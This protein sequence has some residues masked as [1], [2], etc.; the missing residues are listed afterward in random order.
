MPSASSL[1]R[2][3]ARA[4][5]LAALFFLLRS[6]AQ[7]AESLAESA[8]WLQQYLRLDTTNPPGNE[9]RGAELLAGI[10]RREGLAPR[11][12]VTP[13]GRVSLYARLEGREP[14]AVVLLH[15]M[16]VVRPGPQWTVEPFAGEIRR[17]TLMG[18]GALDVKSLGIA[19]L[20]A[21]IDLKRRGVVPRR[22]IVYLAVA[23]EEAGGGQGTAFVLTHYPELFTDAQVVLN[24]G[25]S[26]RV[27]DGQ[28]RWWGVEVAQKRPLWLRISAQGRAGHAAGLQPN[29]A[30]HELVR[31]LARM[32][33]LRPEYRVTP[34]ARTYLAALAPLHGGSLGDT[35]AHLDRAIGPDGPREALMPGMA[36]LFLDTV[37]V[38]VLAASEQI[39][40]IAAEASAQI[41]VR[42]LPDT[43]SG[44]FLARLKKALGPNVDT[45]LVLGAPIGHASSSNS[46]DW[47]ELA[48]ALG[49]EPVV[50]AFI[51]GF[52]DSRYFRD[53]GV[54]AYGISPFA[55]AG[56]EL[57]GIHG[58]DEGIPLAE[59]AAGCERLRRVVAALAK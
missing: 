11:L 53:R 20:A 30:A 35:L 24:E 39:N 19:E 6:P 9:Q 56:E 51:G 23:D 48:R 34:A 21:L 54:A 32:L 14:G 58:P 13:A 17:G 52:T 5:A 3:R 49:D 57:R 47:R 50:P 27:V 10:L 31:A 46:D 25:G 16:D 42:L 33:D 45:E 18:R 7:A 22:S 29:S 2:A 1:C 43:D 8:A 40:V 37:Q 55:L 15:H 36:A 26:N 44:A 41:D 28:V 38:T 12:L 59:F 4:A